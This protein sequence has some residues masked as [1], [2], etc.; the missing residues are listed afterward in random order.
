MRGATK[1]TVFCLE[2]HPGF[3]EQPYLSEG[4][5]SMRGTT[6]CTVFSLENNPGPIEQP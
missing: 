4:T 3:I 6:K 1:C 2:N 5:V